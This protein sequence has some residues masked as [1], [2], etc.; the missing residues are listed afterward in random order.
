MPDVMIQY[1]PAISVGDHRA[2]RNTVCVDEHTVDCVTCDILRRQ[3]EAVVFRRGNHD[4]LSARTL[5]PR[6]CN[7]L[8]V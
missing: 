6:V 2:T 4:L 5:L 1:I 8:R 3:A 7:R